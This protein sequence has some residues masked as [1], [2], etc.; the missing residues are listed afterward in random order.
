MTVQ[1]ANVPRVIGVL[2]GIMLIES[3]P[4]PQKKP[5]VAVEPPFEKRLARVLQQIAEDRKNPPPIRL[6]GTCMYA[7]RRRIDAEFIDPF[8]RTL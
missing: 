6:E 8:G 4:R 2:N 5:P 3:L 7:E 1:E